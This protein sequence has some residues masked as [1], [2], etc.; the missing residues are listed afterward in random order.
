MNEVAIIGAGPAGLS[1]AIQLKRYN[2][3]PLLFEK[4]LVGGLLRNANLVENYPGFG[5]GISGRELVEQFSRHLDKTGVKVIYEEVSEIDYDEKSFWVKTN[6]E[7]LACKIVVLATGTK[8]P[9]IPELKIP[10]EISNLVSYEIY[11]II[12]SKN[13]DIAIIG[14]G[15]AAFDYAL[16][17]ARFNKVTIFNRGDKTRC[18]PLLW[19]RALKNENI[20]Y[21]KNIVVRSIKHNKDGLTLSCFNKKDELKRSF[22]FLVVAIGRIPNLDFLSMNLEKNLDRLQKSKS[23]FII[24]DGRNGIYRQT[25]IAAGDGIKTAM[26]IY[27]KLNKEY[28]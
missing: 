8:S 11:P 27:R 28:S 3:E 25:S 10:A 22:S 21:I 7:N 6:S 17:L 23:L 13:K 16:N 14:A 26:E 19:E 20:S 9:K 24:G 2:I 18:L 1:T 4:N 15:D 5:D 12:E